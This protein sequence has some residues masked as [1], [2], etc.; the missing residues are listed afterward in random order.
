MTRYTGIIAATLISAA[1]AVGLTAC[2]SSDQGKGEVPLGPAQARGKEVFQ[3]YCA[4]CHREGKQGPEL[5]GI[6]R[7]QYLPSGTPANDE[8]V[9][10]VITMGRATMP[11]FGHTLSDTQVNDL[12]AYLHSL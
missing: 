4:L 1:I 8:R 7:K 3:E 6:L 11:G 10:D 2:R 12:I 9:R 5:T